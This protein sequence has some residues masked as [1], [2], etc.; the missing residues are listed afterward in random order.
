M[1]ECLGLNSPCAKKNDLVKSF[2]HRAFLR[3]YFPPRLSRALRAQDPVI[4]PPSPVTR[5]SSVL[6]FPHHTHLTYGHELP[7]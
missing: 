2:A 3:A 4:W 5:R 6:G 1:S 7:S